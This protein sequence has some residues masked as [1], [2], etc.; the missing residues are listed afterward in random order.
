MADAGSAGESIVTH[1]AAVGSDDACLQW[2]LSRYRKHLITAFLTENAAIP[3]QKETRN[4]SDDAENVREVL[5][6]R[7]K[8]DVAAC[9]AHR[10]AKFSYSSPVYEAASP[11]Y[12]WR[13]HNPAV[14]TV[15]DVEG[16]K[17]E[18]SA[19]S[20]TNFRVVL[21]DSSPAKS[22]EICPCDVGFEPSRHIFT[23]ALKKRKQRDLM[24]KVDEATMSSRSRCGDSA[25]SLR[26]FFGGYV[27]PSSS[28]RGPTSFFIFP[29]WNHSASTALSN[30][31]EFPYFLRGNIVSRPA[32]SSSSSVNYGGF[33]PCRSLWNE[34]S[35]AASFSRKFSRGSQESG[36]GRLWF[37]K[38]IDAV[39]VDGRFNWPRIEHTAP[40]GVRGHSAEV[41]PPTSP[42]NISNTAETEEETNSLDIVA[43]KFSDSSLRTS[44]QFRDPRYSLAVDITRSEPHEAPQQSIT[45]LTVTDEY[46]SFVQSFTS[47]LL[48]WLLPRASYCLRWTGG[49]GVEF[50][51]GE[52]SPSIFGK[53]W[54]E[55]WLEIPMLRDRCFLRFR[56]KSALVQPLSLGQ[57]H[58]GSPDADSRGAEQNNEGGAHS[59]F[60]ASQ[61]PKWD[62]G[63]VR[64]FHNIYPSMHYASH[65]YTVASAE[66]GFGGRLRDERKW[67]VGADPGACA[68]REA[69][70]MVYANACF[71]D[72]FSTPPRASV[73]IS[74]I[75]K[76]RAASDAFNF[77]K[78]SSF[79]CSFNWLLKSG[80]DGVEFLSG[81]VEGQTVDMAL[82][83]PSPWETFHHLRC[84]L[85]WDL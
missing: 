19:E 10:W 31:Q 57:W 52:R 3:T 75:G 2:L 62:A 15:D 58:D 77:L 34:M 1:S 23:A 49:P 38:D 55:W 32:S 71:A 45:S 5:L 18:Q 29:Q 68:R 17:G 70:S 82:L 84:G 20:E 78:P 35:I 63:L 56:N 14:V 9:T 28:F 85:T 73:G 25:G 64:G 26:P 83:R 16:I 11:T 46:D 54:T 53:L 27:K 4:V 44:F 80:R 13:R 60:W 72:S 33:W 81:L 61:G 59:A 39:R 69:G 8:N 47:P 50:A 76:S 67:F 22:S 48:R 42:G 37:L 65:W 43:A 6:T 36:A 12:A 40:H 51:A 66:F 41:S 79:E 21:R 24:K 74:M 30:A 7:L